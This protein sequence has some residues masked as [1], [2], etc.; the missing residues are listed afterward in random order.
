LSALEKQN[1]IQTIKFGKMSP[2]AGG[3]VDLFITNVKRWQTEHSTFNMIL[4]MEKCFHT[5]TYTI[6]IHTITT[7][8][9]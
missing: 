4:K 5:Y 7:Q 1:I 3:S 2:I 6:A 8:L 9:I